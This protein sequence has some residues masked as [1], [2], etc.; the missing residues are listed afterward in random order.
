MDNIVKNKILSEQS[1]S[2]KTAQALKTQFS[3]KFQLAGV[4][5]YWL[6]ERCPNWADSSD[7]PPEPCKS[8]P[9]IPCMFYSVQ[10]AGN[11]L[12]SNIPCG[13]QVNVRL[14]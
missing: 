9:C 6:W 4:V 7:D 12:L 10:F 8:L 3:L 5:V 1:S 11:L 13:L 14:I 2:L